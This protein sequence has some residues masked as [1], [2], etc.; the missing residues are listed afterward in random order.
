MNTT[1]SQTP[2]FNLNN[3][4]SNIYLHNNEESSMLSDFPLL[5]DTGMVT[6]THFTSFQDLKSVCTIL[7]QIDLID[8]L[9]DN[10][11]IHKLDVKG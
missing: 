4:E 7:P 2:L 3:T 9:Y 1:R 6:E 8:R 10:L 5:L 11:T